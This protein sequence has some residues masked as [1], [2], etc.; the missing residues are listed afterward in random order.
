VGNKPYQT[1]RVKIQWGNSV[2]SSNSR[3][4][5]PDQKLERG[6]NKTLCQQ[7]STAAILTCLAS[8]QAFAQDQSIDDARTAP[9]SSTSEIGSG[10][11]TLTLTADGSIDVNSGTA[12][13]INGPHNFT[14]EATSTISTADLAA[15]RGLF[16]DATTAQLISDI[17]IGGE[18]SIGNADSA[19][20]DIDETTSNVGLELG[21]DLGLEGDITITSDGQIIVDGADGRGLLLNGPMT[22]NLTHSGRITTIGNRAIG[23]D[24]NGPLTGDFLMDGEIT[25]RQ[26]GTVGVRIGDTLDGTYV[27]RGAITVGAS[28]TT[29]G[30]DDIPAEPAVAGL[31]VESD[32]SGG[33][34]LDGIGAEN[35]LDLDGDGN[36]DITSDSSITS[37]GGGPAVLIRS[38]ESSSTPL[39]IGE[40]GDTGYG[41]V[42]RGNILTTGESDG[43]AA[44]AIRIEGQVD[45][46]TNVE[47]GMYFDQG[48][49]T[50]RSSDADAIGLDIGDYVTVPTLVNSGAF[51]IDTFTSSTV[52]NGDDDDAN[53]D[54]TVF[55]PGGEAT[56]ILVREQASLT[57]INNSGSILSVARGEGQSAYVIRDLSGS[58]QTVTNSG[59]LGAAAEDAV[60][61]SAYAIDVQNN[62]SGFTLNNSGQIVGDIALGIGNDTINLTDGDVQGDI[63]F[64]SGT[65][66][67]NLSGDATFAG[68]INFDGTLGLNVD[69]ADLELGDTDT[70]HFTN[71]NFTNASNLIFN[72]DLKNEEAGLITVDNMLTATSD[73]NLKPVFSNFTD[74][75]RS[76]DLISAGAIDFAD[77]EASLALSDTPFLFDL[78]LNIVEGV[79]NSTVTLNVRPKTA[80][81]LGLSTGKTALYDNMINSGLELDSQLESSLAGLITQADADAAFS[82]LMPDTTNASFNS[83]LISQR[84]FANHL[85]SRLTDF[86]SEDRFE[87]GAWVR[88]VTNIGDHTASDSYLSSDILSVGLTMGYDQPISKNFALGINGGFTLNGFSGNDE[89][90]NS[91]LSSFAPFLSFYALGR[92]GD[93]HIGIQATGQYVSLERERT[94]EFGTIERIVT[95]STSGW[96]LAATAEAGYDLKLGGFHLRPFGRISAQHYS[97]SGYTEEGGESADF[98]IGD[99]KFS[100]TQASFGASLGY[101]FKWKRPRETKIFRPEVFYSYAKTI[102]GSDPAALDAIFVAGDTSFALEIDQMAERVEQYGG[103]FNL[104]G[105]GSKARVHYA[106]E[107]LD[108]IIGH[109]VSVNFALTF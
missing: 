45:A 68:S 95:S 41:Y 56:A 33:I 69:G 13:T 60:N 8:A 35:N 29:S 7:V 102:S 99:R 67:L 97:E 104:F 36:D 25:S 42:Q 98:T 78:S 57:S 6:F 79:D 28:E 55:G 65:D 93:L 5:M 70:L 61:G 51:D 24:L 63:F 88:E 38:A 89:T 106:Y 44:T 30:N 15:G 58:L 9:V 47:G 74:I 49:T 90:I 73:V 54:E 71:A 53:N 39:V 31:L 20:F 2:V 109:A 32:V 48:N 1:V 18:I 40:V 11:G 10:S 17:E 64:S 59:T 34:L 12:L 43:L 21:G 52:L 66:T 92:A 76:F 105:D 16:L 84:Q 96:N 91:E 26:A 85:S 81:E 100:R 27:Q 23:I 80:D 72:V 107:K 108:D 83:A 37:I 77:S 62:T 94:I 75:E 14:M 4:Q 46:P 101:D 19:D 82:A 86:M 3:I 87:G 50:S 103:A 22:G